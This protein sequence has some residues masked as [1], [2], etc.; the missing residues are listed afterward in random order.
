MFALVS[1]MLSLIDQHARGENAVAVVGFFVIPRGRGGLLQVIFSI[2]VAEG[3]SELCR[4]II[5][6]HTK[7]L[8]PLNSFF[9]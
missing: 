4:L 7:S 9:Y 6:T 8:P 5:N 1:S 2:W 3:I